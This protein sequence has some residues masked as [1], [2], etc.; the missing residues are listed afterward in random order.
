MDIKQKF[1]FKI[2]EIR[3]SKGLSQEKLA[4]MAQLHRT[5]VSS[6][7]LGQRNVSLVNIERLAK[8]L[9]CEIHELFGQT[10]QA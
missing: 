8:A 5:Y 3:N 6:L 10:I 1:G 9:D 7:E 2:K 4:E